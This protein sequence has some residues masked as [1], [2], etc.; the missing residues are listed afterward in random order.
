M[1]NTQT[2]AKNLLIAQTVIPFGML[3]LYIIFPLLPRFMGGAN[4][5][6]PTVV[7]VYLSV[8]AMLASVGLAIYNLLRKFWPTIF[9]KQQTDKEKKIFTSAAIGT[10]SVSFLLLLISYLVLLEYL[11]GPHGMRLVSKHLG[12]GEKDSW[13]KR[14][15]NEWGFGPVKS[16]GLKQ[17]LKLNLGL[18]TSAQI[19]AGKAHLD[20]AHDTA[21]GRL[22][23]S[24]GY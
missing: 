12:F 4:S 2:Q 11:R 24:V 22:L 15:F 1:S 14:N 17:L 16:N 7:L 13:G 9:K 20:A 3:V 5:H 10:G 19:R 6:T 21:Y 23:E 18:K 8:L